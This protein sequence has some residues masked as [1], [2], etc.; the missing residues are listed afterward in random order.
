MAKARVVKTKEE[1]AGIPIEESVQI[2]LSESPVQEVLDLKEETESK[3]EVAPKPKVIEEPE[4]PS[5]SE[6]AL[7]KQIEALTQAEKKA[8]E[9]LATERTRS[10]EAIRR[11]SELQDQSTK[12]QEEAVQ[13]QYDAIVNAMEA[14]KETIESAKRDLKAAEINQDIDSRVDATVRMTQAQA[15]LAQLENGKNAIEA[16]QKAIETAPKV[17]QP[18]NQFERA[19]A[20]LPDRA[21]TWMRAHPEYMT[22]QRKNAKIQ[23]F[24]WDVL[25]EGHSQ[26]SDDYFK[27]M[28]EHLGLREKSKPVVEAE[29]EEEV[30]VEPQRT[31]IVTQAPPTREAPSPRGGPA[32][33]SK[34]ELSSEERTI[35]RA[36]MS[37]LEPAAAELEYARQKVKL[38]KLKSNGQYNEGR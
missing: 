1:V 23:A 37:Y 27:S 13:A 18:T 5:E 31:R 6:L 7:K 14:Q 20:Q 9:D 36:S 29:I 21:K 4:P 10:E 17:E 35:A 8:K 19:I 24:H 25:D 3:K 15:N 16:R 30:E 12:H 32:R 34:V 38:Q 22:D 11:Q 26:F 28:E 33:S 2:D